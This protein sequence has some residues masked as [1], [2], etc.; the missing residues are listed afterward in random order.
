MKTFK[1]NSIE[2]K[3]HILSLARLGI[4]NPE[5][6]VELGR[7]IF[8][9]QRAFNPQ[10]GLAANM[11]P[12]PPVKRSGCPMPRTLKAVIDNKGQMTKC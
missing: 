2:E 10:K 11:P 1:G 7:N 5:I 3:L 6:S 12:P 9:I 4:K 8:S